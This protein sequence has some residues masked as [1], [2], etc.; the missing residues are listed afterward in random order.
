M[1]QENSQGKTASTKCKNQTQTANAQHTNW[2]KKKRNSKS[3]ATTKVRTPAEVI[4]NSEPETVKVISSS[5]ASEAV[6]DPIAV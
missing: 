3:G 1:S 5:S 6:T 2:V 4:A